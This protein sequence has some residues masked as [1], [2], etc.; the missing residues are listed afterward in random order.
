MPPASRNHRVPT[1]GD[2]PALT[3]ASSLAIPVAIAPQNRRRSSRVA[4]G[5]RHVE[6]NGA[7]PDRSERRFPLLVATSCVKVLR[8]PG[9]S[10]QYA[11]GPYRAVLDRHG[12]QQYM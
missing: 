6:D 11:S 4:T 1:A 12:G 5:G 3:A 2:T 7:R 8:R 9:Q 10:A